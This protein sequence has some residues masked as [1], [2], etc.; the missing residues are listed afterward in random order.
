[1][2]SRASE[3]SEEE[4]AS[5]EY[6]PSSSSGASFEPSGSSGSQARA[7]ASVASPSPPVAPATTCASPAPAPPARRPHV[8][9]YAFGSL[10]VKTVIASPPSSAEGAQGVLAA[11]MTPP[12]SRAISRAMAR[13][14]P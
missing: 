6:G 2:A 11:L 3:G 10:T 9:R 12:W 13:P 1:M 5:A 7:G 4:A 14:R 8:S